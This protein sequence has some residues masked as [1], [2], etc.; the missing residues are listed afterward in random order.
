MGGRATGKVRT[1]TLRDVT[2]RK[3]ARK[4]RDKLAAELAL[5]REGLVDPAQRKLDRAAKAPI[6]E[7]STAGGPRYRAGRPP[8]TPRPRPG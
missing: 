2:D 8:G 7:L 6:A 5:E 1:R 4:I 3:T